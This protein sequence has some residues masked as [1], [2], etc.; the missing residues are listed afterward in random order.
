MIKD[1]KLY[2][3][4]ITP[5]I[6][7]VVTIISGFIVPRMILSHFGSTVNGLVQSITQFLSI[8]SFLELGIGSVVRFNL[9]KPLADHD[10]DG[11]SKIVVA[12][13]KF[14]RTLAIIL[15]IYTVILIIIFP[16]LGHHD[17]SWTYTALLIL[18]MVI[19]SFSQY[20]F[21]QVNQLLLTA[22]Q[23]GYIQYTAQILTIILNTIAC[24]ILIN[25]GAEIHFVKLSTSLIFLMRPLFLQWYVRRHYE[26]DYNIKYEGEPIKQ[27]WNGIAQHISSVVLDNTDVIVLTTFSTLANVSIYSIYHMIVNGL[28]KLMTTSTSGIQAKLGNIIARGDKKELDF[29]FFKT[30]W[31]IHTVGTLL[32]GITGVLIVSFVM[33]YTKG[34]TDASYNNQAFALLMTLAYAGHSYR[35]PYSIMILAAGHYKQTQGIYIAAALINIITSIILVYFYGLIGVAVGTLAAMTFQ[36]VWMAMYVSK[37]IL[38]RSIWFFI[39]Q[40]LVDFTGMLVAGLVFLTVNIKADSYITWLLLAVIRSIPIVLFVMLINYFVYKENVLWILGRF[41]KSN[42]NN[43]KSE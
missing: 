8:I 38:F 29:V 16:Y 28:K 23:K 21:G 22:D 42:G 20:F 24:V 39:K 12:A 14:F 7:E 26:I 40:V 37:N 5:I 1:R 19:S 11:I 33:V 30:E 15:L 25:R 6:L 3:N 34:I 2:L 32:F 9:Y 31:I 27:K 4:T 13:N 17:F 41:K 18:A 10:N 43:G 36:T 35:L